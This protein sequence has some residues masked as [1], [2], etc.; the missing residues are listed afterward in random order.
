MKQARRRAK[1]PPSGKKFDEA[2]DKNFKIIPS[3]V[4][5]ATNDD[6]EEDGDDDIFGGIDEYRYV[7]LASSKKD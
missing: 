1:E 4:V 3:G 2:A 5:H 7:P 6:E